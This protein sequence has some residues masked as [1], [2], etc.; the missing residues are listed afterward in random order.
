MPQIMLLS[1]A[2]S[3]NMKRSGLDTTVN[4]NQDD[5]D[6]MVV[7]GGVSKQLSKLTPVEKDQYYSDWS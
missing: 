2:S 7:V 3:V 1:H 4:V 6:P 5:E